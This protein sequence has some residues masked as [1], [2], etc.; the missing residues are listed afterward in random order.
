ML[1]GGL[2]KDFSVTAFRNGR[3]EM[4]G[5]YRGPGILR[6]AY[7]APEPEGLAVRFLLEPFSLLSKVRVMRVYSGN[8]MISKSLLA[9]SRYEIQDRYP[10]IPLLNIILVQ[11]KLSIMSRHPDLNTAFGGGIVV[12]SI[13]VI[14]FIRWPPNEGL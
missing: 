13:V 8:H 4:A 14:R 3:T 10:Q 7:L 11:R 2:R 12:L 1:G 5:V 6:K 9:S